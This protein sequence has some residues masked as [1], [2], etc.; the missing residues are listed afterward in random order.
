MDISHLCFI[1]A[2]WDMMVL[3]S[4]LFPWF[5]KYQYNIVVDVKVLV[6]TFGD[7]LDI[8]CLMWFK[9]LK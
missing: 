3:T 9:L 4:G 1:I 6:V 5:R 7:M 8:D 2:L